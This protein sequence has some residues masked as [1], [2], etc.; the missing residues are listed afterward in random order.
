MDNTTTTPVADLSDL[1]EWLIQATAPIPPYI[2]PTRAE[3][4]RAERKRQLELYDS[5]FY[6]VMN[7]IATGEAFG[8]VIQHRGKIKSSAAFMTWI[9]KDPVRKRVFTQAQQ[10]GAEI[11]VSEIAAISD[12]TFIGNFELTGI[13]SDTARDKLRIESRRWLAAKALPEKYGDKTNINMQVADITEN[14]VKTMTAQQ[15]E[16]ELVKRLS[17]GR[18]IEHDADETNDE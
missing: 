18:V 17:I 1:P 13:P 14:T 8:M 16:Q 15:V 2:E 3:V 10:V 11:L 6:T 4:A 9:L 5:E 12:G 7:L